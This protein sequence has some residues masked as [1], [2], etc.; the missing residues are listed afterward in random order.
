MAQK[1]DIEWTDGTWPIVQGCDYESPGCSHCYAVPLLWRLS[2]NPNRTISGPLQG[3]V[4]KNS[5]GKLHFTGKVALREDRLDWPLK[6]RKPMKI[7]LPSHGDLFHPAVPDEFIDK[8]F[9]VMALAPQ[10]TFQVL[11][12]HA[13]RMQDLLS[14]GL[15]YEGP[16]WPLPNVHIGVTVEDQR[17]ADERVPHLLRT[18]AS[19]RW[20]SA[21]PLLE[22]LEL[23]HLWT[24]C[25]E[26]DFASGF[27]K[28]RHHEG[29]QRVD[30]VVI[31]GES[32]QTRATTRE[33]HTEWARSLI[34]QC[35]VWGVAA[36]MKQLGTKPVE[37]I[38]E[39]HPRPPGKSARYKWHEPEHWPGDLRVQEFPA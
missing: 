26:H 33:F 27:C 12:K 7:F 5:A 9:A 35:E 8:V 39:I 6:W 20:I 14:E 17:R 16:H 18:P 3:V 34:N 36:F 15:N 4:A 13:S 37:G 11:T 2:H 24:W 23:R 25:P 19:V 28:D 29:V 30:W 32:A 1:S 21:E 31:G 10:H 22:A 38:V